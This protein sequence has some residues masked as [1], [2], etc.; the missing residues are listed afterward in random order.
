ME[1]KLKLN[2]DAT[3]RRGSRP[4]L[5]ALVITVSVGL[6]YGR[7]VDIYQRPTTLP[8]SPI[9]RMPDQDP[10][11]PLRREDA[12]VFERALAAGLLWLGTDGRIG[13]APA[14][15][16]LRQLYARDH[17]DLLVP[18]TGQ[19]DGLNGV[20]DDRVRQLHQT[21]YFSASGRYVRQ[22]VEA[23]NARQPTFVHI[24]REGER[25]VWRD[26]ATK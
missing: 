5:F 2:E 19:P 13:M 7:L 12:E 10:T 11:P 4:I 24:R 15:L 23:F 9:R 1:P 8:A 18:R 26:A 21:L 3:H 16:P 25:L 20:W 17:P 6:L 14:D 22:Q